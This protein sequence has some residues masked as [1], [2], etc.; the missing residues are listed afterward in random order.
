MSSSDLNPAAVY[1]VISEL[2]RRGVFSPN[3]ENVSLERNNRPML[4][5]AA[6]HMVRR[7]LT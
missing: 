5:H 2:Y 7:S 3:P 6:S 1:S 4:C